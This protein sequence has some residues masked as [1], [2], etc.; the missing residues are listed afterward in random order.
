MDPQIWKIANVTPLHKK[1][2]KKYVKNYR[3]ISLTS[4]SW[5]IMEKIIRDKIMDHMEENLPFAL[6]QHGFRKGKFCVTQLLGTL[7]DWTNNIDKGNGTDVIHLDFQ[8]AFDTVPHQRLL[9]KLKSYGIREN[10]L[11]GS[12]AF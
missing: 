6:D 9:T 3:P 7:N 5:K 2:E 4:I 12:I 8:K 10:L 1:E 11:D